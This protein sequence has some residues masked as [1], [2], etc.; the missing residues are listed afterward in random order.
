MNYCK[1]HP[2]DGATY[3]CPQCN[4]HQCDQCVDDEHKGARCFVCGSV[5]ESLGSGN[6]VEP[7]WRR[8]PEAFKYPLNSASMSLI[9]ITSIL[10]VVATLIPFLFI[11]AIVLYL[12][13]VGSLMKYSFTC[14][15][16]TAMGEMKAPDVM[17]AYQGGIKLL[18]Q[19]VLMT[20]VL[21]VVVGVSYHY[22]G[23]AFGGL[24]GFLVALSL[25]AI[26]IR[27]A[28]TENMFEAMNPFAAIALMAAIGLPY[29]LLIV[30]MLIMM[31]SVGVLHEWIGTLFPAM[32]YLLQAI[33]SNYY[34]I[35]MF[36]LMGYML[37]QYQEQL[38]YSARSDEDDEK[39]ER[40]D[41]ERMRANIMVHLKE[42][43]YEQVVTLYYQAFK[44][45]PNEAS[46][47]EQ[48]F[49][50]LYVCKKTA[51]MEDYGLVYLEF[52]SRKKRFDKLT[53]TFK[54]ILFLSPNYLPASASMRVQLA[55]LFKQNGD[56]KMAVRLLNGMHK[57]FADF[58]GLPDAYVLLSEVLAELPGMQLQAEK[59]R[60]MSM[61]LQRKADVKKQ[62][63]ELQRQAKLA[64][65]A[66]STTTPNTR[67][68]PPVAK[69]SGLTLEL[70]PMESV[71][72]ITDKS[73]K[74]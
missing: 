9:V 27:F 33:I 48:F 35:V 8:L 54:Q 28:Q 20:I 64:A 4:I 50:L 6:T 34:T 68:A 26:L 45:F 39:S 16:R 30:F 17:D 53:S 23:M 60:Q 74:A 10:S 22:L 41:I 49:D 58:D 13:A 63:L 15:E 71:L 3:S 2:L 36:H 40:T 29:G 21:V 62:E 42:G 24:I 72:D 38:G 12:F 67:R 44:R 18:L 25:P 43:D 70:V 73:E 55:R 37:F 11:L 51:L 46:F 56:L 7:F 61:Q 5:L 31:T 1:Y 47:F 19:L 57:Q 59:C 14:L 66:K 69:S 32:S 52:L 65:E